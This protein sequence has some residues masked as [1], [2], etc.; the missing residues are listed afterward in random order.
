M[1][2]EANRST[3][4][5]SPATKACNYTVPDLFMEPGLVK[6]RNKFILALSYSETARGSVVG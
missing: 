4:S 5:I 3:P 2:R 6:R 1:E